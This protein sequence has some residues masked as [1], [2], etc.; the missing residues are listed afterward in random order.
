MAAAVSVSLHHY[1]SLS[2]HLAPLFWEEKLLVTECSS[3][4]YSI[5]RQ[6][7]VFSLSPP[8]VS[9][10]KSK[11]ENIEN[12]SCGRMRFCKVCYLLLSALKD[13]AGVIVYIV[14]Y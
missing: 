11:P 8:C 4:F 9:A 3:L 6:I 13:I 14:L 10:I 1:F 5:L 7:P 2:T 12:T